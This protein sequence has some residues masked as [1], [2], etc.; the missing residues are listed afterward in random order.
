MNVEQIER[1]TATK[2]KRA[3]SSASGYMEMKLFDFSTEVLHRVTMTDFVFINRDDYFSIEA[4]RG[5]GRQFLFIRGR[6][7]EVADYYLAPDPGDTYA[8]F[9]LGEI[10]GVPYTVTAAEVNIRRV[11]FDGSEVTGRFDFSYRDQ[12]GH[13]FLLSCDPFSVQGVSWKA[14]AVH[15][16]GG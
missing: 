4:S 5:N 11:G 14:Q 8:W 10:G 6:K 2:D 7:L 3:R 16:R 13:R 12:K 9:D 15:N 1:H